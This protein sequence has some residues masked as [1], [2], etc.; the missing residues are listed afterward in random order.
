MSPINDSIVYLCPVCKFPLELRFTPQY[1]NEYVDVYF[2]CPKCNFQTYKN[3]G[4]SLTEICNF[5]LKKY[6]IK[7][8]SIKKEDCMEHKNLISFLKRRF[9]ECIKTDNPFYFEYFGELIKVIAGDILSKPAPF[10]EATKNKEDFTSSV[11]SYVPD[12]RSSSVW[13]DFVDDLYEATLAIKKDLEEQVA[14]DKLK[15][16]KQLEKEVEKLKKEI[17]GGKNGESM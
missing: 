15:R 17:Y 11:N 3:D 7:T 12:F 1:H 13:H 10:I 5:F 6:K 14:R 4:N 9:E 16:L 2:C 8:I